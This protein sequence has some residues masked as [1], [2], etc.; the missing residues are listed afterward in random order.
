MRMRCPS[1]D[2]PSLLRLAR[3]PA[4]PGC[5]TSWCALILPQV[6]AD[7]DAH[8]WLVGFT[9]HLAPA[10]VAIKAREKLLSEPMYARV[11]L[12]S[13]PYGEARIL[14]KVFEPPPR[15]TLRQHIVLECS[16]HVGQHAQGAKVAWPLCTAKQQRPG[17]RDIAR[18]PTPDR[19]AAQE[20][21]QYLARIEAP[22]HAAHQGR[23][24]FTCALK[25]QG[26]RF[27]KRIEII[28]LGKPDREHVGCI[29]DLARRL[30]I[31]R[32][33]GLGN[34]PARGSYL[35]HDVLRCSAAS[36]KYPYK[37]SHRIAR[38]ATQWRGSGL[39]SAT[40][41]R[42]AVSPRGMWAAHRLPFLRLRA[43]RRS[44]RARR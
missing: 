9:R 15:S 26:A 6:H 44:G 12:I 14:G 24:R 40:R 39:S 18:S 32:R 19:S 33:P 43:V 22:I 16:Q 3:L 29:A 36:S 7:T 21:R 23:N 30:R 8:A 2:R 4:H 25:G 31:L 35:A 27:T 41:S 37:S 1:L 20:I 17:T 34:P 42:S 5:A 10:H 28:E 38:C 11:Q 13:R